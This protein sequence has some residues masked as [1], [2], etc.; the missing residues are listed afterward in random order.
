VLIDVPFGRGNLRNLQL[1]LEAQRAGVPVYALDSRPIA[2]RDFTDGEATR[3][4][5]ELQT[6]GARLFPDQTTLLHALQTL[7]DALAES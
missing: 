1:A 2:E 6:A 7:R 4:W 3:L 5:S